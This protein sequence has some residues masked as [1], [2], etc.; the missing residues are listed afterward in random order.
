MTLLRINLFSVLIYSCN[1]YVYKPRSKLKDSVLEGGVPFDN[2]YGRHTFEY[3]AIDARFNDVFNNAMVNHTKIVMNEILNCYH[4]FENLKRLVDVGG[5]LGINL[6]MIV[7][8]HPTIKGVNF[9]LPHVIQN[10]PFYSGIFVII[11]IKFINK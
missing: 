9:D 2:V 4:G 8:K 11:Y 5:C 3:A 7:S 6:N 10:A 1:I